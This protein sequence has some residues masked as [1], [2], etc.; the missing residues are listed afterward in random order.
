[1]SF[2]NRSKSSTSSATTTKDSTVNTVDNRVGGDGAIFGG[3]VTFNP[4]DSP[5]GTINLQQTDHGAIMAGTDVAL[6][7][8]EFAKSTQSG[9]VDSVVSTTKDLASQAF[10]SA[11][12]ARKSETAGA[13]QQFVKVAAIV[14]VV[15]IAAYAYTKRR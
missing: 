4:G 14:A 5:I 12:E 10:S 13:I 8:L 6:E 11:S 9:F 15:A 7:S 2:L 3:N 1:M